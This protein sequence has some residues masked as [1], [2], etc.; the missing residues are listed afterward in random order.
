MIHAFMVM[1]AIVLGL[2]TL[3][4]AWLIIKDII[5]PPHF[6]LSVDQ[7]LDEMEMKLPKDKMKKIYFN[8]QKIIHKDEPVTFLYWKDD[9]TGYNKAIKNIEINP[10]GVVHYCWNWSIKNNE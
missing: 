5:Q 6:L 2:A 3:D 7:L 4:L 9:I 1:M 8:F 10:L